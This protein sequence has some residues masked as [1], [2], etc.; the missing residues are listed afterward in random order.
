MFLDAADYLKTKYFH[1][2]LRV[3]LHELTVNRIRI[4]LAAVRL[5]ALDSRH[6][7]QL[8]RSVRLLLLT[9]LESHV[10]Q[11]LTSGTLAA[12]PV[13]GHALL[14][15]LIVLVDLHYVDGRGSLL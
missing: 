7:S 1:Q 15:V 12:I 5:S 4:V 14:A 9:E 13:P 8:A 11:V 6:L 2:L 3:H 10:V